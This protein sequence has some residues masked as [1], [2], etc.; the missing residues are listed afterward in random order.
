MDNN[1][2]IFTTG[3]FLR[4]KKITDSNGYDYWIWEAFEFIYDS[5]LNGEV[6]NPQEFGYTK[7]DLLTEDE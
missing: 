3:A 4:P 7:Q 1:P 6:F 2:V 5:Y